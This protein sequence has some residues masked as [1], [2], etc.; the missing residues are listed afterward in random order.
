MIFKSGKQFWLLPL[1]DFLWL[2]YYFPDVEG[3]K[4]FDDKRFLLLNVTIYILL[5]KKLRGLKSE[6][7]LVVIYA[8]FGA[9]LP[10]I[11]SVEG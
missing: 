11:C 2:Q 4:C 1:A 10:A 6:K 7:L 8:Y 3:S 9:W 5:I